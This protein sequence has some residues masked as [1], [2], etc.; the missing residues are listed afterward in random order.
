GHDVVERDAR[1]VAK[2]ITRVVIVGMDLVEVAIEVI[3]ALPGGHA[4]AALAAEA[5]LADEGG[6]VAGVLE[7]PG[8]GDVLGTEVLLGVAADRAVP[9]GRAG[10]RGAARRATRGGAGV[11]RGEAHPPARQA[12]EVGG[13]DVLLAITAEVAVTEVVGQDEDDVRLRRRA[14]REQRGAGE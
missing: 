1:L 4:A 8:R 14:R 3:K 7:Q 10:D 13:A 5:P 9:G 11:E 6:G 12:V 2:E